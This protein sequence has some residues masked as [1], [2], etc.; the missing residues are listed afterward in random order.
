MI[1]T[2]LGGR[3]SLDWLLRLWL[4]L[5]YCF[6]QFRGLSR[7]GGSHR[8][9][10]LSSRPYLLA[11]L[12]YTS[13]THR[14]GRDIIKKRDGRLDCFGDLPF[15]RLLPPNGSLVSF[16]EIGEQRGKLL[17]FSRLV[18]KLPSSAG[19]RWGGP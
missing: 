16:L 9:L 1:L 19:V 14:D 6:V 8:L 7:I 4:D 12:L 17:P 11:I 10:V 15:V 13:D 3:R 2:D 18:R 5:V